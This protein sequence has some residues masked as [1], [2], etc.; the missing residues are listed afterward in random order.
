MGEWV[1]WSGRGLSVYMFFLGHCP[2]LRMQDIPM[3]GK[4][5]PWLAGERE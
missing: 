4:G 3:V 5:P 1:S 2:R